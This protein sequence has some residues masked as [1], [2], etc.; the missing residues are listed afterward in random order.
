MPTPTPIP[1]ARATAR[2]TEETSGETAT[3]EE[4]ATLRDS[5]KLNGIVHNKD[6]PMAMLDNR[7]VRVGDSVKGATIT[8]I[9]KNKV[10]LSYKNRTFTLLY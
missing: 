9:Q 7:I 6:R 2:E 5:L 10:I 3:E 4:I 1:T 8:E